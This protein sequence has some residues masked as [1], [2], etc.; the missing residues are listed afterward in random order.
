MADPAGLAQVADTLSHPATIGRLSQVCDHWIYSACLCFGLDLDEQT[1]GGFRYEY[2][3][4][5][6]EYSRNLVFKLGAQM[7]KVFDRIVDRTRSRL[8][9]PTLARCSAPNNARGATAAPSC[10]FSSQP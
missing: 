3:V 8:D 7:E 4:Y 5:Q 9:V 1:R 10:R 2:S 6:A